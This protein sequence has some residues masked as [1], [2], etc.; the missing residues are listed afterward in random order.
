MYYLQRGVIYK[1][2]LNKT[3]ESKDAMQNWDKQEAEGHTK[4][5]SAHIA[6]FTQDKAKAMICTRMYTDKV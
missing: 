2:Y 4:N 6:K 5:K 3:T 1:I